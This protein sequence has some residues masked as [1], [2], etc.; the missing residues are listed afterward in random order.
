L[1][2]I[3]AVEG[4]AVFEGMG[5]LLDKSFDKIPS[6]KERW[7]RVMTV[8]TDNVVNW[9]Q[10]DIFSKKLGALLGN[11][12][13]THQGALGELLIMCVFRPKVATDYD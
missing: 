11:Y 4:L 10:E 6:P 13:E 1:S 9:F 8:V 5:F 3:L 7:Q 2:P 12:G